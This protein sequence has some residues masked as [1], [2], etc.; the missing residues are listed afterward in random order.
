MPNYDTNAPSFMNNSNLDIGSLNCRSLYKQSS[1]ETGSDFI[2]YLRS[3]HLDLLCVQESH[4]VSAIQ[5]QLNLQLQASS[6]IWTPHC[7]IISFNPLLTLHRLDIELDEHIIAC[8]VSHANALFVPFTLVNIYAPAQYNSRVT[9]FREILSM[10]F[11]NFDNMRLRD[12]MTS[13]AQQQDMDPS[14]I[15][16]MVILGGF[17]YH[18]TKYI[19]EPEI[20]QTDQSISDYSGSDIHRLFHRS[21]NSY[22][23]ECT[24]MPA[25][26]A[27]CYQLSAAI[28]HNL[29]LIT[30]MLLLSYINTCIHLILCSCP[31]YGQIMPCYTPNSYSHPIAKARVCGALIPIYQPILT[32]LNNCVQNSILSLIAFP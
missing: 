13:P 20:P 12:P 16:S 8:Q 14:T 19:D 2:R 26:M 10:P 17:N 3:L 22:F 5:E 9:F 23:F 4:A 18:A 25:K 32:S 21:I 15:N 24:H 6:T 28:H 11:F 31:P 30:Y 29:L 1:P 27:L 7:G